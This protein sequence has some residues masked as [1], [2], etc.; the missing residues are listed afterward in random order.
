V[1]PSPSGAPPRIRCTVAYATRERQHL[2]SIEL[3]APATIQDALAAARV[4]ADPA[5]GIPWEAAAVG[6]F[7]A[8]RARAEPVADGD[9]IELYRPLRKDPREQRRE[10]L[11]RERRKA[12]R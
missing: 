5:A 8:P 11:Q 3:D 1:S 9:R 4:R 12:R 10:R 2:I 7:G 6:V